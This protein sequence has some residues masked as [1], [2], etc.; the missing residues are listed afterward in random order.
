M[1]T[2]FAFA[3]ANGTWT[4]R[5]RDR[6]NG[7]TGAVTAA[8][9]I[10][11]TEQPF[12]QHVVDYDGDGITDAS[13]VRN[14]GGG[15]LG[16]VTW[17]N[18]PTG[19]GPHTITQWGLATDWFTPGDFDGDG[20]TDIA[21]WRQGAPGNSSF[22]VLQSGTGTMRLEQFGQ[23][24]DDPTVIGDYN[25]DGKDDIAVY[26]GDGNW[27]WRTTPGGPV[28]GVPWGVDGDVAAPGDYDG[29]GKN[30]FAVRRNNGGGQA[31]FHILRS[32]SGAY[33]I[34]VFGTPSDIIVPGDYDGDF[35]TDIATVRIISG[36]LVW[37]V[38]PSSGGPYTYTQWGV[39]ATD[40][41]TPGDYDGDGKTDIAVWRRDNNPVDTNFW[42]KRSSNGTVSAIH[43]G[44]DGDYAVANYSS[45]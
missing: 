39:P 16:Q 8:N 23:A 30:D 11:S 24:G 19:A 25:G 6:G 43:W 38:L 41:V 32:G 27:Y 29:D 1:N 37:L 28:F 14:T 18:K 10:L 36:Q 21:V 45:H 26:R 3:P 2:T 42:I 7:D 44:Q 15:P 35:K 20:K 31:A 12:L 13:V 5:F 33:T 22:Y 34:T 17:Y 40:I 9:L 4:L